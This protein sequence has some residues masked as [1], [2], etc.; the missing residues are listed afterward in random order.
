MLNEQPKG[1][2]IEVRNPPL[3]STAVSINE[4]PQVMWEVLTDEDSILGNISDTNWYGIFPASQA[5]PED[6]ESSV[7]IMLSPW[8]KGRFS[9]LITLGTEQLLPAAR[10]IQTFLTRPRAIVGYN[11]STEDQSRKPQIRETF[12]HTSEAILEQLF[13]RRLTNVH[14][15]TEADQAAL[16]FPLFGGTLM[17][18]D[19]LSAQALAR[20]IKEMDS[21]YRTTHQQFFN[22]FVTNYAAV[23]EADHFQPYALRTITDRTARIQNFADIDPGTMQAILRASYLLL[24]EELELDKDKKIY[25]KPTYTVVIMPRPKSEGFFIVFHPQIRKRIGPVEALGIFIDRAMPQPEYK[26]QNR[27]QRAQHIFDT[28]MRSMDHGI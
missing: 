24:P 16:P 8:T 6:D 2:R 1:Y 17:Q 4:D 5:V 10:F 14:S 3:R 12:H 28:T 23:A 25:Q 18:T 27:R 11:I 15:V 9:P 19:T 22:L 20:A 26:I 21:T 13:V 7:H